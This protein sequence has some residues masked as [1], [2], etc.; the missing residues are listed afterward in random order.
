MNLFQLQNKHLFKLTEAKLGENKQ[1][2]PLL[3]REIKHFLPAFNFG[4]PP[5]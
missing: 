5:A 2:T 3:L 4:K 1:I